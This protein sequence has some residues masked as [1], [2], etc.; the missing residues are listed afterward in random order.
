MQNIYKK[1]K[2]SAL[3]PYEN[4]N[5]IITVI[6]SFLFLSKLNPVSSNTFYITLI[7]I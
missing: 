2:I 3:M 5:K 7:A 6:I 4:L 1:E